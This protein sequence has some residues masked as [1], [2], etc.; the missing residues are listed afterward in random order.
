MRLSVVSA[1]FFPRPAIA[2][3]VFASV[4]LASSPASAEPT[5]WL[6]LGAGYGL[7]RNGTTQWKDNVFA[8]DGAIGVGTPATAPIVVGG[9]FR[10]VGYLTLG[11]DMSL[12]LRVATRG[13]CVGDWGV[14]ID[15]GVGARLWGGGPYGEYPLTGVLTLGGPFGLQIAAGAA[16]FDIAGETPAAAGG[17][18]A[19]EIDLLR[20]TSMRTGSTT[21]LWSNPAP[22]NAPPS[23]TPSIP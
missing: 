14:A 4:A 1:S 18:V 10:S 16:A 11:A 19:F 15:I 21:K 13:Y 7:Q 2:L 6:S 17:F 8:L 3:A 22:A 5:S 20:L 23:E 12:S 9:V